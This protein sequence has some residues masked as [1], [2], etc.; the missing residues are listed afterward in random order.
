VWALLDKA[1]GRP[2]RVTDE[3]VAPFL[4]GRGSTD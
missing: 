1:S 2:L 4:D 3:I